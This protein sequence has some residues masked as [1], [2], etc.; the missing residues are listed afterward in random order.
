MKDSSTDYLKKLN[1]NSGRVKE[2]LH[3]LAKYGLANSL[4][5]SKIEWLNKHLEK[6]KSDKYSTQKKE[7]RIRLALTELGTTFIKLGQLLSTRSDLIGN[8]LEME[9]RKLQIKTKPNSIKYVRSV[10]K[11]E[12]G[13]KTMEEVFS[14]FSTRPIASASIGQ[15]HKASLI[16][17]EEVVVKIIHEGIEEKIIEDMEILDVL[18][19]FAEKYNKNIKQY[20]PVQ[21][22]REFRKTL[23]NELDFSKELDNLL[24]FNK[25]FLNNERVIFPQPFPEFSGKQILTMQ[26]IKGATIF[27]ID[28]KDTAFKEKN[29]LGYI[30][31]QIYLDMIFRDN[32]F[33][34][35][36][37]PG[38]FFIMQDG[39]IG[40]IDCGMVGR[41][42]ESNREKIEELIIAIVEKDTEN[43]KNIIIKIGSV[44]ANCDTDLLSSQIDD[45]IGEYLYL[46]MEQFD[47]SKAI[48]EI[49]KIIQKHHI[50]LPPDIS[51]LMRALVMF[52]GTARQLNPE[53]TLIE[54]LQKYYPKIILKKISPKS[55]FKKA[56]KNI[57]QWENVIDLAPKVLIKLLNNADKRNFKINLEHR[58]LENSVNSLVTGML[59]AALFLGSS[60]IISSRIGPFIGEFSLIGLAGI[61][62]SLYIG[63]R[64]MIDIKRKSK[65]DET[66]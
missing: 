11:K 26:Q 21:T 12:L 35:D 18:A 53:F 2:I 27:D 28:K 38:N 23:L 8:D 39:S 66:N 20:H 51:L 22:V 9:L 36:P 25:N 50:M 6:S 48:T 29:N 44:P 10:I 55:L 63:I 19:S 1:R 32:F 47:M 56:R 60:M 41:L 37:H 34:A 45:F 15:V 42:E 13:I 14:K 64:L 31:A 4:E 33:H 58:N 16:T 62:V 7:V 57:R 5:K 43:I 24:L 30:G 46:T 65:E 59:A 40:I 3:I 52:E 17:G 49:T 54:I 61:F